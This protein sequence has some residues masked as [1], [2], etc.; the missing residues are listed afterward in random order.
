[1]LSILGEGEG[2]GYR[3]RSILEDSRSPAIYSEALYPGKEPPL[4]IIS[5]NVE[6][7]RVTISIKKMWKK[8]IVHI[9][10][11]GLIKEEL[12][13]LMDDPG[14]E[15]DI[16]DSSQAS[17]DD[18]RSDLLSHMS[19]VGLDFTKIRDRLRVRHLREKVKL[20]EGQRKS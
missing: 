17:L 7:L 3:G 11:S 9:S 2:S 13:D 12:Y 20:R 16:C 10:P 15:V 18:F 8:Y 5:G 19:Q 4:A 14:E 1:M 6:D